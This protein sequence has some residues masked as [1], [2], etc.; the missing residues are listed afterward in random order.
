MDCE[1][2]ELGDAPGRD[3][4]HLRGRQQ[5][6]C[7]KVILDLFTYTR[8]LVVAPGGVG[9]TTVMGWLAKW[10]WETH[11]LRTLVLENRDRL[12][13]QTATRIR[14]ET[15]LVVDVE[16]GDQRASPHAHI[17]VMCVQS[18]SKVS[19]LLGFA[20][21]HFGL[22]IP[23]ECHLALSPS[24]LRIIRYFH[25]GAESLAEDWKPPADGAYAPKAKV[26]GFTA[27]P[28]LGDRRSLGELFHRVSVN[29]SYLEAIEEG[30]LVGIR[31]VNVP[32]KID[33]RKF[34]RTKTA[35]G[36]AFKIE[37]QNAAILPIIKELAAQ[38]PLYAAG[39]KGIAFVPSVEIARAMTEALLAIGVNA[40]FVSGECFDKN[41]KTDAFAAA[42]SGA[43]L[44]NCCLYNYGVDFPDVDCV[45][46]FGAIISKVKYI[47]SLYRGTRVL[48]GI[49][50]EG[51]T[52]AQ[53]L[54]AI[55]DSAKRHL[56]VISPF[57][58]SDRIDI[59]E[60]FDMFDD[61]NES[62]KKAKKAP[63]D[64]TDPA[65]IR[66]YIGALEKAADPHR[67]RQ[68]RTIDPVLFSL[69]I[70][71]DRIDAM[72]TQETAPANR[73]EL[74]ALLAFG[75]DTTQVKN[76]GQAQRL[77]GTLRERDR[78]GLASP[79]AV[80]QLRL[81]LGWPEDV[82]SKIRSKQ[83]GMLIAKGVR[84]KAPESMSEDD[85]ALAYG[86]G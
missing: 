28:N 72:A 33:T 1:D 43:W 54:A 70:G 25:Y 29:Y 65:K 79:V 47:Q 3:C 5:E 61:R 45:A 76:S 2:F 13:E 48:P 62:S 27:S 46:I 44:I 42:G 32:V 7:E 20:D 10:L 15:G 22:C 39:K 26:I 19:R 9:K 84:Y 30:W 12:T 14:D 86:E 77:I 85:P 53:R 55:A 63:R 69:S 24:W 64:L 11:G 8:L 23:D 18:G 59:C 73:E 40:T 35:E 31:E 34:R 66:D 50:R 75:I 60:P 57:F 56:L 16:K 4:G 58:I 71:Q 74:D 68:A 67:N 21:D 38:I 37:D 51:M 41:D 80:T 49:L 36:A 78:L 17:V 52:Q 82:A 83:A 6:W 81:R